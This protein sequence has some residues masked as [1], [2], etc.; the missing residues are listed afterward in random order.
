MANDLPATAMD[1][2]LPIVTTPAIPDWKEVLRKEREEPYFKGILSTIERERAAGQIIYPRNGDIFNALAFTPF[3]AVRVVILGQDPYHG[4]NQAHGLSFSV[5]KG[6]PPPPSLVNIFK[7]L[8]SDL[9]IPPPSH[10]CLESWAR[11]GVLLLNATL[12]VRAGTP[13]SHAQLGWERFTDKIISALN[14]QREH[15]VFMLW[16]SSAQKKGSMIDRAQHC[17][18][19]APH[20]SPLSAHRGFLGCR[21]FSTANAYLHTHGLAEID[22]RL[23]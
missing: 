8:Q 23:E 5:Q 18:L 19:T 13:Q 12:T 11:R 20:P 21:H 7:E 10:G 17:V 22:W 6:V 14:E 15:L 9:G 16:G 4:P 1:T 3:D 2:A